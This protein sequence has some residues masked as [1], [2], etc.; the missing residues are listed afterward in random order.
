[1]AL[2]MPLQR[3]QRSGSM[4]YNDTKILMYQSDAEYSIRESFW[5]GFGIGMVT[6]FALTFVF[7]NF[8][9]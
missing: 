5:Y 3:F 7:Y 4:A 1:M 8:V 2:D 6:A 9:I